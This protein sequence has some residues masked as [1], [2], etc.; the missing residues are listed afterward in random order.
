M[1]FRPVTK[2]DK[3]NK[4]NSNKID[5]NV[6]SEKCDV[7]VIFQIFGQFGGVWRPDSRQRVYKGYVFSKTNLLSYGN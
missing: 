1:K 6:I 3:K 4:T 2:L 5:I 7:I